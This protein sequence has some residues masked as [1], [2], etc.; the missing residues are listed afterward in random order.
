[1]DSK[2]RL[3]IGDF[4]AEGSS[5]AVF[6]VGANVWNDTKHASYPNYEIGT[7]EHNFILSQTELNRF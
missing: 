1:M 4:L 2:K 3:Y 5:K 6:K 7:R